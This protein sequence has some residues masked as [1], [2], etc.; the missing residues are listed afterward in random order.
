[1][2]TPRTWRGWGHTSLIQVMGVIRMFSHKL[3]MKA[4]DR[5]KFR[6]ADRLRSTRVAESLAPK[7][8][9]EERKLLAKRHTASPEAYQHFLK[10][11]YF[12]GRRT[13]EGLKKGIDY[14][15]QAIDQD[16]NYAPAFQF[17]LKRSRESV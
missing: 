11:R 10:G 16:P 14:F 15:R 13:D 2:P 3:L 4:I 12:W 1:M 9:G 8:S 17:N 7:L 6:F 5:I